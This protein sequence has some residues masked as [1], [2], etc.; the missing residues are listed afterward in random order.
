MFVSISFLWMF[1]A[2]TYWTRP[3]QWMI[4]NYKSAV[5]LVNIF[6][7]KFEWIAKELGGAWTWYDTFSTLHRGVSTSI[8]YI[9]IYCTVDERNPGPVLYQTTGN[10]QIF[11]ISTG[12]G[13]SSSTTSQH[14]HCLHFSAPFNGFQVTHVAARHAFQQL[15]RNLHGCRVLRA[16]G[17][18]ALG[19]AQK[20]TLKRG[21]KYGIYQ[22][23]SHVI[24]DGKMWEF[25]VVKALDK[26]V[27]H[28]FLCNNR[29]HHIQ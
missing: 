19:F 26:S 15:N 17:G 14:I 25:R 13:P 9:K 10:I 4:G 18:W 20:I 2:E 22:T 8:R 1:I 6:S 27:N 21:A 23:I 28:L 24:F 29:N 3:S 7:S 5:L 11:A 16:H 12:V